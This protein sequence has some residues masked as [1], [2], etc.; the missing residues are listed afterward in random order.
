MRSKNNFSKM[1]IT[2]NSSR[3]MN[4]F[5]GGEVGVTVDQHDH[6]HE[7]PEDQ[8]LT[9]V[10][11]NLTSMMDGL[12]DPGKGA[13]KALDVIR[14]QLIHAQKDLNLENFDLN[15]LEFFKG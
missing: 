7:L 4:P 5:E 2:N 14:N 8:D 13:E 9:D 11:E 6:E 15:D 1:D 10:M 3:M 12:N